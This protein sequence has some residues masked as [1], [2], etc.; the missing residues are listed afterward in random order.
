MYEAKHIKSIL[1]KTAGQTNQCKCLEVFL[2]VLLW[3]GFLQMKDLNCKWNVWNVVWKFQPFL[4]FMILNTWWWKSVIDSP[5]HVM[6][7]PVQRRSHY[8][9]SYTEKPDCTREY[10]RLSCRMITHTLALLANINIWSGKFYMEYNILY[11]I[12]EIF[13]IH[14]KNINLGPWKCIKHDHEQCQL[15]YW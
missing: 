15:N 10:D 6:Q 12:M 3:Y 4:Q 8:I 11:N 13:I 1:L 9:S 7:L 14:T 2:S 5:V